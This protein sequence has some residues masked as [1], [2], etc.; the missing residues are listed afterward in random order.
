MSGE[1]KAATDMSARRK[2]L[3]KLAGKS[4]PADRLNAASCVEDLE[5]PIEAAA[6]AAGV[7]T[8]ELRHAASHPYDP[9]DYLVTM[10][11]LAE[12]EPARIRSIMDFMRT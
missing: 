1:V 7:T 2:E 8:A 4:L 11:L 10:T 3:G 5:T 6:K 12:G 9:T